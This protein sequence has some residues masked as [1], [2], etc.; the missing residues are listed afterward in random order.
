MPETLES[1][2]GKGSAVSKFLWGLLDRTM[3]IGIGAAGTVATAYITGIMRLNP[4][5]LVAKVRYASVDAKRPI[6]AAVGGLALD[7]EADA[8]RP[9]GV[10]RVDIANEGRGKASGVRFQVKLPREL[11]VAYEVQPDFRY[12]RRPSSRSPTTSSTRSWPASPRARATS[13]RSGWR[14]TPL[15]S[16]AR[17]SSS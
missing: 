17:A 2:M 6:P 13:W 12:I 8:P 14:A 16:K 11:S 1:K 10:M 7:Y 3:F 5:E 9:Y 15:G 4:P